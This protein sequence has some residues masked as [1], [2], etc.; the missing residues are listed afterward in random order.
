MG[1]QSGCPATLV[2]SSSL[3]LSAFAAHTQEMNLRV[4]GGGDNLQTSNARL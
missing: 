4:L 2:P 1:A 3:C